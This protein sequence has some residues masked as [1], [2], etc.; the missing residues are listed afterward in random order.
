MQYNGLEH[1]SPILTQY[2]LSAISLQV[3]EAGYTS[4]NA[5]NILYFK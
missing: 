1:L 2:S 4:N 3:R 5:S